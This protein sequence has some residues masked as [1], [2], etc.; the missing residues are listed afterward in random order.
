MIQ[1]VYNK[2]DLRYIFVL[3][4]GKERTFVRRG[5]TKTMTEIA[6][7]EEHLNKIPS[8][9]YLPSF[10]GI[11]KPVVFLYKKRMNING[12]SKIV[13]FCNG[14]LWKEIKDW[15]KQV[16]IECKGLDNNF[17]CT[18]FSMTL[19]EFTNYVNSWN[20]NL[21]PRDYQLEA[22]WR[23]LHYRCSLSQLAT[24]SGKT[25]IAYMIF[26]Y[27]LEHGAHN[28]L[29][30]VP[31][32]SLVKQGVQDMSEY[33]E[34]FKSETVWAKGEYAESS[35]LTIGT[36]QSLIK[37]C[38]RGR[39]INNHYNP[40]FF[41]KFDVVCIDECH[42]ADCESIK[43]IL[44][45]PFMKNVKIKFGFS[46]TLPDEGSI[47]SFGVQSL[48]GPCVQDISSKELIDEGFLA[49]P[50]ITQ[51]LI[52]YKNDAHMTNEY[53][54]YGEYLCSYFDTDEEGKRILLDKEDRDMT[55]IYDKTKPV[56]VRGARENM[57]DEEYKDFLVDLCKA[58]G[59]SLL[60]LEQMIAE[61]SQKKLDVIDQLIFSFDKNGIVF[62]HNSAYLNYLY[63]YFKEKYP[64][65]HIY[66]IQGGTATKKREKI[67]ESL[68]TTDTNAVLFASY[69]CVG[70]GLTFKNVD[71]CVF[72]QSFKSR[73]INMQSI[74]RGLL[75]KDD[76][77][78]FF[79]YDLIDCLPT[80]RLEG[81]GKAKQRIYEKAQY[82]YRTISM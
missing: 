76:K 18:D 12:E 38:V 3:H 75:L 32:I 35:N 6:M 54:K 43:Q 70:T 28:I 67:R 15:C 29:M 13:H 64:D 74:G 59:S 61:H 30:V 71:Y 69:G 45:Q 23:I 31:N 7:L 40:K 73:I 49:K 81:H 17:K 72:A 57:N 46:G 24:R 41:D 25:L 16:G 51:V 34:F 78:E 80:K 27:M 79:V 56:A 58:K 65:R 19:E 82:Q 62:A 66:L 20:L 77:T 26:R 60:T 52:H 33:K 9:M 50:N 10:S 36:F 1:L 11:P 8:Y 2:R 55:M 4:D 39:G 48:L 42:K 14:G 44:S 21:K 68:N 47:D 5:K 22:A 53:I 63:K 37:R